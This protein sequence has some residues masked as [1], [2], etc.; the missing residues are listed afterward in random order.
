MINNY[1]M[2]VFYLIY[3]KYFISGPMILSFTLVIKK[4]KF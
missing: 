4:E 1:Y 3:R 2:E